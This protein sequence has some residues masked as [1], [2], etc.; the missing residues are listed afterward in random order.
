MKIG[1]SAFAGDSG[2]SGISQYMKNI[3]K[4]LPGLSEEDEYVM[5]MSNSDREHFDFGHER[6]RIV[7]L[8][9]WL[10][11]PVVNIFWHLICLPV[12]L[13][14]YRCDCIYLP[15][16]NRRLAWWYGVPSIGTV[17]DLSQLHVEGKYDP[18]RMFYCKKVLPFLIRKLDRVISV[19]EATRKDLEQYAGVEHELIDVVYNGADLEHFKHHDKK[20]ATKRVQQKYNITAPYILYTARLEHPGKNHVRL[21]EAFANLKRE[22]DIPHHL[23]LAGSPWFGAEAIYAAARDLGISEYVVFAGFVPNE[24]LPDLYAGAD[25]FAFP[26][27]FEGFGIPLLEA[28]ASGTPVVASNVASIPEVVQDAGLLFDPART[29]EIQDAIVRLV[30][31]AKLK[32]TLVE[33]GLEQSQRF[34]WDDSAKQVWN[35]C[36]AAV[37]TKETLPEP[38][39][40]TE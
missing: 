5:F 39:Q 4:R 9:D 35:I 40:N 1:I 10:G 37:A 2:K 12:M 25:L 38:C 19:S 23:I 28:M 18:F 32:K 33:L 30:A 36:Q 29:E 27:L 34:S 21:L 16:A 6:V 13:A 22:K 8:P 31:D 17:H 20:P 24:E 11:N 3:F 14:A 15:A 7:S 26:S